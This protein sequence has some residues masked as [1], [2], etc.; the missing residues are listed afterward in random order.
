MRRLA[1][2]LIAALWAAGAEPAVAQVV[3]A[4]VRGGL[5]WATSD[6]G[7]FLFTEDVGTRSGSHVGLIAKADLS[8]YFAVQFE[9]VY[10]QKGFA[11]GDGVVALDVNYVELPV[12]LVVQ[13]PGRISPHLLAGLVLGLETGCTATTATQRDVTCADIAAGPR[14]KGADSGLIFG[15]GVSLDAGPGQAFVDGVYNLGLTDIAQVSL[16]VTRIKTRTFYASAGYM[17][18]IGSAS[19]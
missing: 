17:I 6:V 18:K 5:N 12:Y 7:G 16:E 10:S 8:R 4:G 19:R 3:S 15:L 11:E 1:L 9:A 13:L 14:T 2:A